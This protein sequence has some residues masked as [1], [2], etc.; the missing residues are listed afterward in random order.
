MLGYKADLAS[1][2]KEALKLFRDNSYGLII[3]DCNMPNMNGYELTSIIR[4]EDNSNIP[5][6][7]LSADAFPEREEQ[8][9]AAGMNARLIKPL[10]LEILKATLSQW[11]VDTTPVN[12]PLH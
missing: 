12:D 2:G 3:T 11:L 7:A 1:D 9:L 5:V 6:I 8:C 10:N 4:N